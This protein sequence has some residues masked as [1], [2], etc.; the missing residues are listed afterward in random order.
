MLL[1]NLKS[2]ID[3]PITG[4]ELVEAFYEADNTIFEMCVTPTVLQR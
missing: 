1:H 4:I 3:D 2:S